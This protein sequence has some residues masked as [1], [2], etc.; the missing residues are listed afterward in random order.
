MSPAVGV[1]GGGSFGRGLAHA[2]ARIGRE[3]LLYSR[4]G[5]ALDVDGVETVRELGALASAELIFV[6]VPSEHVTD[7]ARAVGAHLDGSHLMV[8]VSRGL[9][10]DDLTPLT[11]VLR[12]ESPVRRVGALAGPLVADALV[13]GRPSGAI[14]GSRF[15]EVAEAVREAIGGPTLRIYS[16]PDTQG[17]E[18]GSAMVGLL[19]LAT[20]LA[21]GLEVG[22]AS[23]AVMATRGIAEAAR[24][25]MALGASERTFWGLAGVGDLTAVMAGDPR[26][27]LLLAAALVRGA[28]VEEACEEA[29]AHI[30]GVR[31]ARRVAD[32]AIRAGQEAP[33]AEAVADVLEGGCAP[34]DV[35]VRLMTRRMKA[36]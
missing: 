19:T 24:V 25:G 10:G 1:L 2:A 21:R 17:V 35:M 26:P 33:I 8:H 30:E 11:R 3:V 36:E 20:G 23:L 7:I 4:G 34:S 16:T 32:Y 5:E 18:V 28:S 13:E 9:S 31:L 14:V 12:N 6:A 29:G 22:P 15:P 27:E